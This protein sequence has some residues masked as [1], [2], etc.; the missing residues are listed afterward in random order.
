LSVLVVAQ[1]FSESLRWTLECLNAQTIAPELECLLVTRSK[2]SVSPA[3]QAAGRL[4]SLR[5][6]ETPHMDDLGSAKAAGILAARAPVV[7]LVED[8][9]YPD[10]GW[11]EALLQAHSEGQFAAVGSVVWNANPHSSQSWGCFLV[12]YGQYMS[13][14]PPGQVL[15]L[16]GNHT[17]Y[18]REVLLAYGSRLADALQSET[19]LQAD[20]LAQGLLLHHEARAK[21]YHLNYPRIAPALR[22]ARLAS[23]V[24]AAERRRGWGAGKRILYAG[25]SPLLPFIRLRRIIRQAR[26]AAL[27]WRTLG[28]A[29]PPAFAIL[30][31]GAIGEALGYG[32]GAGDDRRALMRFERAHAG[33]FTAKD[34]DGIALAGDRRRA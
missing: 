33:L 16:P 5:V 23:R 32:W 1:G 34:L 17:S 30:C 13:A 15:H 18:R 4:H 11:A 20:V 27:P 31:A 10:P 3:E 2:G 14:A 9:S 28:P 25:G 22:V 24:F 12:Y 8:H 29:L 6:V 7:A 19:A 21:A 26:Q